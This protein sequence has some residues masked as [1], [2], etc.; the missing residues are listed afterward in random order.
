MHVHTVLSNKKLQKLK[1]WFSSL[2]CHL[3]R[4]WIRPYL[5]LPRPAWDPRKQFEK[6]MPDQKLMG[7]AGPSLESLLTWVELKSKWA[8]LSIPGQH[9]V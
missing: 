6:A 1:I 9:T 2:L 5:Q 3:A 7:R 4:R 8:L